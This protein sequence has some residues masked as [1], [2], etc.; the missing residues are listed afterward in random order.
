MAKG[1]MD[2]GELVPNEVVIGMMKDRIAKDDC[3]GGFILDGF[4]RALSQ[5]EALSKIIDLDAV[6]VVCRNLF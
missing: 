2:K 3:S 5:A 6:Q 1:Y 4:P